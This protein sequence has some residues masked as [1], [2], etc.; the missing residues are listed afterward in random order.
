MT[1][2]GEQT[3]VQV[4]GGADTLVIPRAQSVSGSRYSANTQTLMGRGW[5]GS[6][7]PPPP[8]RADL[9]I[10]KMKSKPNTFSKELLWRL[11]PNYL[12]T[13]SILH[14]QKVC[15][16]Q[17]ECPHPSPTHRQPSY[18]GK[19][20]KAQAEGAL[21]EMFNSRPLPPAR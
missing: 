17:H 10:I 15:S 13:R 4:C 7:C 19:K 20:E 3:A 21:K 11:F 16:V 2:W 8:M 1:L 5:E 14:T 9:I 6:E 18:S 12:T